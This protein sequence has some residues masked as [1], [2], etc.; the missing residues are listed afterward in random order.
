LRTALAIRHVHFED[1]GSFAAPIAAA[2]YQVRY[3]DPGLDELRPRDI[4]A[5]DLLVVLGGPVGVYEGHLYPF[6]DEELGVLRCR[7]AAG[8]PTLGICLG[9]QLMAHALGARVA[10]GSAKEIGWAPVELT[11]AGRIG[12]LRH[13]EGVQMLH[14]HGD[15]FD[16]PPGTECLAST[17]PCANQAFALGRTALGFQFHPEANGQGFERWLVGHAAEIASVP[18]LS[19]TRLRVDAQRVGAAAGVAGRRCIAE[20]FDGLR[21]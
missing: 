12:P 21:P 11:D 4:A 2:G 8:A 7:L 13:L 1:L 5:A 17:A 20:W 19:V 15:A 6:L 9:A 16:L 18:G 10:P 14:W 3:L